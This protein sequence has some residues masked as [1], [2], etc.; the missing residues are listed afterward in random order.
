VDNI[1][2]VAEVRIITFPSVKVAV[3]TPI[4]L[5]TISGTVFEDIENDDDGDVPIPTILITLYNG[6][7]TPIAT[8]LTDSDGL[9][10]FVNLTAG[11]YCVTQKNLNSTYTDVNDIDGGNPNNITV[12][13][14]GGDDS[15]GND[16]IDERLGSIS[17]TVKENSGSPIPSIV[18]VLKNSNNTVVATTIT[19]SNGFYIFSAVGPSNYTVEEING[20]EFP[21]D[22]SD[23]D[24]ITDGDEFDSDTTVD[25]KIKVNVRP[26]E[27][28]DGN[29]F[30]DYSAPSASPSSAPSISPSGAPSNSPTVVPSEFPSVAPSTQPSKAASAIPSSS[31]SGH[32]VLHRLFLRQ[33]HLPK[34]EAQRRV[35]RQAMLPRLSHLLLQAWPHLGPICVAVAQSDSRWKCESQHS[36]KH[37]P[38]QGR[39]CLSQWCTQQG[40]ISQ[41]HSFWQCDS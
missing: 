11:T 24:V 33:L 16:F 39:I 2:N 5:G 31:P 28:D 10:K 3:K 20:V 41:S 15:K 25:N 19:D 7:G 29:N 1:E 9:Y 17:G 30:I 12:A 35:K 32:Q 14:V 22:V 34:W 4:I 40:S 38:I 6:V 37:Q 23:Y 18:L 36:T 27:L 21:V 8:T 26:A 13:I